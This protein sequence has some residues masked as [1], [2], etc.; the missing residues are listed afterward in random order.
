MLRLAT[1]REELRV[2]DDQFG[3]PTFAG[4]IAAA[5]AQIVEQIFSSDAA[6]RR[7]DEG[8]TVHVVNGGVTSWFGFASE[9]FAN[10][11]DSASAC[12]R[13]SL[14]RSRRASFRREPDG[15]RTRA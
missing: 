3:A 11:V 5:T 8:D 4:F 1:E 12:V 7:V 6:R 10:E 13:L 15:R 14:S 2:V 9:I